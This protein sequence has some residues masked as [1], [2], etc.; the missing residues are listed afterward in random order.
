MSKQF[1][2]TCG[3]D[4]AERHHDV[5]LVDTHGHLV[6]K[7]RIADDAAGF[8][9]LVALLADAGDSETNPI[10]VAIETPRG[11]LVAAL[12]ATGRAVYAINPMAVA[13]HRE[14]WSVARS[15]SDHADAVVLA[16]ILRTDGHAHR[17]LPAD[18]ELAQRAGC[19]RDRRR[20][21]DSAP[22]TSPYAG[23]QFPTVG[24]VSACTH[25]RVAQS[26]DRVGGGAILSG[27]DLGECDDDLDDDWDAAGSTA[28]R[29]ARCRRKCSR[30][31]KPSC[32]ASTHVVNKR[33][34]RNR[35]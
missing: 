17:P 4:W 16:N 14:R 10:P 26:R 22:C 19:C 35:S 12:R 33:A 15:K 11:L 27:D 18:S 6:A 8:Q 25:K 34:A 2:A 31:S 1:A 3:I 28:G 21:G 9:E 23:R 29:C 7:R 24:D 20:R 13:R 30:A 32:K 5:A